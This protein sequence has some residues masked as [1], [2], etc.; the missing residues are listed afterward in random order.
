MRW[1]KVRRPMGIQQ[2]RHLR[3]GEWTSAVNTRARKRKKSWKSFHSSFFCW[4]TAR[5]FSRV[6]SKWSCIMVVLC[7]LCPGLMQNYYRARGLAGSLEAASLFLRG[8]GKA[9]YI[10]PSSDPTLALLWVGFTEYD[11]DELSIVKFSELHKA[12]LFC[13]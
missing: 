8:R 4:S 10:L 9:L 3:L 13:P 12:C 5:F 11:D 7:A 2:W 6:F 1:E